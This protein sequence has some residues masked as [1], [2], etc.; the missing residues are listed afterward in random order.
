MGTKRDCLRMFRKSLN[1]IVSTRS[2]NVGSLRHQ[3][4]ACAGTSNEP[5]V[6]LCGAGGEIYGPEHF[7]LQDSLSKMIETEINP[8]VAQWEE[9][10]QFP[11][12]E[13]MKKFGE[14]GF[15]GASFPVEDG[16]MGLDYSYTVAIAE[17]MGEITCGAIP[18]AVGVQMDMATPGLA[19]HGS[20]Y[21][22]ELF[23]RPSISGDQVACLG[24]SEPGAGS[25]VAQIKTSAR[26]DGDDYIINGSKFWITNGHNADWCCLLVNT[27][28]GPVHKSK[29][30]VCVPMDSPGVVRGKRIEK[31]GMHSSDTAQLF[32]EDVR[33]PKKNIIGQEGKGF[34]YQMQQ[35]QQ[36]RIY[37]VAINLKQL[38]MSINKTI[39]YTKQRQVFGKSV[40]ENQYVHYR[41][42]EL[43]TEIELLR[44][45]TYRLTAQYV[46]GNDVTKLASMCKLKVGRLSR[47]VNDSCLQFWG[48]MGFTKENPV[49]QFYRDGRLG[50]IGGGADEVMLQIISK[51]M[52]MI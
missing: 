32:F 13:V 28:D 16:G 34:V 46:A 15:L 50:S 21:V 37:A 27:N 19:K 5:D 38:E 3:S 17:T 10:K 24:V 48:G 4:A 36:E 41:L 51:Y 39:E 49:S 1:R 25:D 2:K 22:R 42:A 35:F 18:M 43:Q 12:H 8:Y 14:G 45:L 29:S 31:I 47:E 11:V 33:V 30:L 26:S 6:V 9:Q 52:G 23:L 40:I 20:E 7:A 44:A